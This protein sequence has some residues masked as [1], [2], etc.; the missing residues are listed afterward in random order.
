VAIGL[1]I[2][3]MS[4]TQ[5]EAFMSMFLFFYPA[6]ML[7]GLMFPVENMPAVLRAVALV[8]PIEHFLVIVRGVFLRGAGW[9]VLYPEILVLAVMG[10]GVLAFS[11]AR[12]RKTA[13]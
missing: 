3:T 11:M 12:F 7:S 5:Q 6:M 1:L 13:A 8:D 2:S 9:G 10:L 4:S